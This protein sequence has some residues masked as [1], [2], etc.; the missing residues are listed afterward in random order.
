[1]AEF[2]VRS[3]RRPRGRSAAGQRHGKT[4]EPAPAP[5]VDVRTR[6]WHWRWL[7]WLLLAL[8][9]LALLL[10]LLRGCAPSLSLPGLLVFLDKTTVTAEPVATHPATS[11]H[12]VAIRGQKPPLA[13]APYPALWKGQPRTRILRWI[14]RCPRCLPT[15]LT[16][17]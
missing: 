15:H 5:F 14:Q 12:D 6:R 9:L 3:R 17:R 1:L 16:E 10:G 2:I 4:V 8:L 11:T 7:L 13:L